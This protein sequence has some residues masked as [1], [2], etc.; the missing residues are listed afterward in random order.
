MPRIFDDVA[1]CVEN[2]LVRVGSHIVLALP[3][4]VGKPN[5]LANEFYRRARRDPALTL[6]IF[7]A[8]SLRAP[9]WHGELER[10]FLEPLAARLFGACVPLD[11]VTDLHGE[12]VPGNVQIVEFFLDPGA[13][14]K[15]EHSQR[16]Y[17]SSNYTHVAR[18]VAG[19]GVNV[20]AQLVAKRSIDGRPEYSLGSNPDVTVDLLE[21]LAPQRQAGREVVVLGEVNRQMPFMFGPAAVGAET[22]D[23]IVEHARYEYDL[24]APPN[25]RLS[26]VDYAIGLYGARLVRDGGTLQIGIGELGDAVVY[27]LQLRHQQ[28]A[29]FREVLSGL[30]AQ[31]RFGPVLDSIG[32]TSPF[33]AGLY[34]CTEMFVDGFL[35][36][37]RSGVLRRRVFDDLRMQRLLNSGAISERIDEQFLAAMAQEGFADPFSGAEFTLLQEAG[38]FRRECRYSHGRIE[39]GEGQS[40]A[41]SF[42]TP[43]A[44]RDLL[45][46][47]TGRQLTGGAL[48]HAAFFL[49]PRGFYAALRD[50][51]ET[52][53]RQFSM[54]GVSFV[55]QL[56]GRDQALKI[57]QRQHGRFL[58]S[59]MMVT[60]L[61]SAV[62][63]GLADGRVV[64]GVGGQYNF[65]AMAHSLPGAR[66][67]LTL[68]ST[69]GKNSQLAS[70]IRWNYANS[71]IPRH[72]RDVVVTE[73][74][75]ADLRGL[76]DQDVIAAL[77]DITDSRFQDGLKREAQAAGK[78]RRDYQIADRH[79]NNMPRALEERF[80][81]A[82]A[83]GLFSEFPFGT[84]FTGEE[85]VLAK[86][87]SNIKDKVSGGWPRVKALVSAAASR[88]IP[89]GTRQY[90]ER[91]SLLAPKSRQE[92]LWQRLLVQELRDIR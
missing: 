88:G 18:D 24:F 71:T 11:Y 42:A 72:L 78:L 16:H 23:S 29:E 7:T 66:S 74:G 45:A 9:Q 31:E 49:G 34:G 63:D 44:R 46:L 61:G 85:I 68:R 62:S 12:G 27:G 40:A 32:D 87:L 89:A 8:L 51:P 60:L 5:P 2:T 76:S 20:I 92:W 80:I 69:R 82:R 67:I 17:V 73:Y 57:A 3:L 83:R 65:V 54:C 84:D 28:N 59:T 70:N 56:D 19:Q 4:G 55:N 13:L 6:K 38:V 79:R 64:S 77:L 22:F 35:D 48:L 86:A 33:E 39:N 47:C 36:L 43:N 90:L 91:M 14:L 25:Q 81:L 30:K 53:R 21:Y 37:Y 52:E 10:R 50:L 75:V 41:A 26:T 1:E 15:V 58:N